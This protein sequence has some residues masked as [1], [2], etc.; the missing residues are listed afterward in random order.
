MNS[1]TRASE[2]VG[3][4]LILAV[5]GSALAGC[6][7][8]KPAPTETPEPSATATISPPTPSPTSTPVPTFTTEPSPTPGPESLAITLDDLRPGYETMD[9]AGFGI[10]PG[11]FLPFLEVVQT[12]FAYMVPGA[13]TQ[14]VVG[15]IGQRDPSQGVFLALPGELTVALMGSVAQTA[16]FDM[17]SPPVPLPGFD[18]MGTESAA[19]T[20]V[21]TTPD[22]LDLKLQM[23]LI[24]WDDVSCLLYIIYPVSVSPDPSLL[25]LA[26]LMDERQAALG[27]L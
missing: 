25:R 9:P 5:C 10:E 12:T 7:G 17:T 1:R 21:M 18:E 19:G 2:S 4:V 27:G 26:Q 20:A 13:K 8:A 14:Y 24:K 22:G 15:A 3:L 16:G 11:E 23:A 6:G